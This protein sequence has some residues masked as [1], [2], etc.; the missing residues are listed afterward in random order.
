MCV[1]REEGDVGMDFE[2]LQL[3]STEE[4]EG[5]VARD[6]QEGE[7]NGEKGNAGREQVPVIVIFQDLVAAR[8]VGGESHDHST[9]H[10]V[11]INLPSRPPIMYIIV[12]R[13]EQGLPWSRHEYFLEKYLTKNNSTACRFYRLSK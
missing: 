13:H 4:G 9:R 10:A 5:G 3:I 7:E 11:S 1:Y 2:T 6:A 8:D 12:R